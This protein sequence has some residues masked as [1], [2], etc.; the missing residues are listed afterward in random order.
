MG[1]VHA[2]AG[3]ETITLGQAVSDYLATLAGSESAGTRRVYSGPLRALLAEVSG[4]A[5]VSALEDRRMPALPA[6]SPATLRA[7]GPRSAPTRCRSSGFMISG[8]RTRR[9]CK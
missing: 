4:E 2:L 9:S 5:D 8:I 6:S 1:T 3:R 7:A